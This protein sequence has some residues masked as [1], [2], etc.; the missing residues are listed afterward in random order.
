MDNNFSNN[1]LDWDVTNW[2]ATIKYWEANTR[3]DLSSITAL[4]IGAWNGGLSLWLAKKGSHVVCTDING[5]TNQA[6]E[7]HKA[8]GVSNLISYDSIDAVEMPYIQQFDVVMFKSVLGGIGHNDHPEKQLCAMTNIY[9]ALKPGG[10]L[11]FAENL[12]ASPLHQFLRRNFMPW[13]KNWR[14]VTI[15]EILG[16]TSKFQDVTYQTN[17]FWGAMGRSEKVRNILGKIDNKYFDSFVPEKWR[18]IITGIARK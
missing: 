6:H 13:G 16:F 11:F 17:G 1:I 10:E 18:Y 12:V 14:Y 3:Q 4:E 2:S 9:N 7:M 15:D 8:F 5:P